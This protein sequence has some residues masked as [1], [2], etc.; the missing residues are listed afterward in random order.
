MA[1]TDNLFGNDGAMNLGADNNGLVFNLNDVDD[2]VGGFEPLP[3]GTYNAIVEE[4]EFKESKSGNPMIA[5][6]YTVTDEEYEN[7]VLF[8]YWVLS[9]NGSE[10]GLA[11]LKK[12][13]VRICPEVDLGSFNP[14]SFCDEGIAI[15]KEVALKVKVQTQ[16]KGD[17]KG[18]KRNQVTEVV[19]PETNGMF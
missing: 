16:K 17:Y 6:K 4:M 11:K 7:R 2:K 10:F 1:N 8:D 13:L 14:E 5:V 3:K 19:A 15:N 12:F 9:G 18:E